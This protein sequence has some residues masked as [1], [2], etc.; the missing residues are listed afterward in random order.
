MLHIKPL[1]TC[2]PCKQQTTATTTKR[3]KMEENTDTWANREVQAL[4]SIYVTGTFFWKVIFY[5]LLITMVFPFAVRKQ[6]MQAQQQ[7]GLK[8]PFVS[9][10]FN[11]TLLQNT[12]HTSPTH[13]CF[14][15][16]SL[17]NVNGKSPNSCT[18]CHGYHNELVYIAYRTGNHFVNHNNFQH[19]IFHCRTEHFIISL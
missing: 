11:A 15:S 2:W 8:T 4:P 6:T 9:L 19:G 10:T 7:F 17:P 3:I 13:L 12:E 16:F 18:C 14:T 1:K 5:S